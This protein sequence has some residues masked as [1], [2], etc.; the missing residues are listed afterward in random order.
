MAHQWNI[1][2]NRIRELD[3]EIPDEYNDAVESTSE[4]RNQ[5]SHDFHH[6]PPTDRFWQSLE[7]AEDFRHWLFRVAEEYESHNQNLTAAQAL[8]QI[9]ERRLMDIMTINEK[10]AKY[11]LVDESRKLYD[12]AFELSEEL[13]RFEGESNIS[14]VLVE[15]ISDI[16]ELEDLKKELHTK[17]D[18]RRERSFEWEADRTFTLEV[19]DAVDETGKLYLRR[20]EIGMSDDTFTI[21]VN[22][23]DTPDNVTEQL[24]EVNE[25]DRVTAVIDNKVFIDSNGRKNSVDF[26][27][28]IIRVEESYY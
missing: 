16:L 9:G 8:I 19:M 22:H 21:D 14:R 6:S 18:V 10:Y 4:I 26:I 11:N 2:K 27:R 25:G 13:S 15:T 5:I 23:P 24:N 1:I 28:K 3:E 7:V 20:D 12:E 17:V